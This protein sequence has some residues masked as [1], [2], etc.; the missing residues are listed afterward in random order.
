MTFKEVVA[1]VYVFQE[2]EPKFFM[3][4]LKGRLGRSYDHPAGLW[5]I[6]SFG[7]AYP[8]LQGISQL[9]VIA[10][11]GNLV[12]PTQLSDAFHVFYEPVPLHHADLK[13]Q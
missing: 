4:H 1:K 9:P 13:G 6:F 12:L 3:S 5:N 8:W 10:Q 11:A 2:N 7:L